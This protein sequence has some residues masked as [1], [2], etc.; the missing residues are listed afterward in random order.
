MD[1][2]KS[3]T[4]EILDLLIPVL[5]SQSATIADLQGKVKKLEEEGSYFTRAENIKEVRRLM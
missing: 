3:Q 4:E 2:E 5:K 1:T